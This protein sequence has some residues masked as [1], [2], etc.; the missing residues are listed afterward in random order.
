MQGRVPASTL[1]GIAH[2]SR[3]NA[4]SF[5]LAVWSAFVVDD[6]GAGRQPATNAIAITPAIARIGSSRQTWSCTPGLQRHQR[7]ITYS[8]VLDVATSVS[9][10]GSRWKCVGCS[11]SVKLSTVAPSDV[12]TLSTPVLVAKNA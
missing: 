2:D 5:A 7:S 11:P 3:M 10:S 12:R 9:P 6:G 8:L 1:S 4:V